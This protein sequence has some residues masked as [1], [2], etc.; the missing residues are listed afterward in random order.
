[1][2]SPRHYLIVDDNRAF[3]ENLAEIL[4]GV[5]ATTQLVTSGLE[6]VEA[7]RRTRFSALLTD[8]RMPTMSGF[9]LIREI[10]ALDPGLPAVV[11]T[12]YS[13]DDDLEAVRRAGILSILP[14][15][16]PVLELVELLSCARRNGLVAIVEDDHALRDNLSEA[17]RS[18]GFAAV[19]AGSV[20][21]TQQLGCV[22]PFAGVVDLRLPDGPDGAA[23]RQL[24]SRFPGLPVLV[25]SG[26]VEATPD[27]H[28]QGFFAKPFATAALLTRLEELH[29]KASA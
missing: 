27:P 22:R 2:N 16:V 20:R 1:M 5:G 8:M 21:E 18:R 14:K 9:G 3:A 12:A 15:P 7:V 24:E 11:V 29:E 28:L 13:E 26:I 17:F 25:I 10:R 4:S 6:A 23:L 19:L